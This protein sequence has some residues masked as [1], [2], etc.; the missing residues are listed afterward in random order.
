MRDRPSDFSPRL[1]ASGDIA[2]LAGTEGDFA[3][4]SLQRPPRDRNLDTRQRDFFGD[5]LGTGTDEGF[6]ALLGST[7]Q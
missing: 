3:V 7:D 1:G 2:Q 4:I 5:S 6:R